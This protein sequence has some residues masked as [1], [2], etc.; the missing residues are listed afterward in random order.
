MF[1]LVLI[2]DFTFFALQSSGRFA[3]KLSAIFLV[4]LSGSK[5]KLIF[6]LFILGAILGPCH[7]YLLSLSN[8]LMTLIAYPK[9]KSLTEVRTL[10]IQ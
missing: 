10:P 3:T 7:R 9:I 2:V 8:E 6:K 5:V 4:A 1:F